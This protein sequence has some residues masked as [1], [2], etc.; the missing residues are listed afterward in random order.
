MSML[1]PGGSAHLNQFANLTPNDILWYT[2]PQVVLID[3]VVTRIWYIIG[4]ICNKLVAT[5]LFSLLDT[6]GINYMK[7][8]DLYC[9]G[10]YFM[11]DILND[12]LTTQIP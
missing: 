2:A 5:L 9:N 12:F 11:P 4:F 3:R 7:L 6:K 8:G 10:F 1:D